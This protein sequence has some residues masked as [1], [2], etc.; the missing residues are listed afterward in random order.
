MKAELKLKEISAE[1]CFV[2]QTDKNKGRSI[3]VSPDNSA[4]R[5]LHYGRIILDATQAFDF[6]NETHETGL[7]CLKGAA[8]VSVDGESFEIAQFCSPR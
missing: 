6:K 4:S 2:P 8:K 5:H 7:I 1:T 3:A